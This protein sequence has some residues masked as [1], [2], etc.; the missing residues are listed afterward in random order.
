MYISTK[1]VIFK[2][3]DNTFTP[4]KALYKVTEN[5]ILTPI[6]LFKV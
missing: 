3:S 4:Q 5:H 6:A 2:V 1:M